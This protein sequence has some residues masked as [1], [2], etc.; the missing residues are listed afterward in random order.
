MKLFVALLLTL[1]VVALSAQED[2]DE[3]GFKSEVRTRIEKEK[4]DRLKGWKRILFGC[5]RPE[6]AKSKEIFDRICDRTSTN[7]KFL[8]ASARV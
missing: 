8:A 7:V 4:L 5:S 1:P 6:K 3:E 2:S